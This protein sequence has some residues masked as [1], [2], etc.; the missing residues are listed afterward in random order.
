MLGFGYVLSGQLAIP[1]GLH[2]TWNFF[3][4]AVYGLPVSG[5]ETFGASFLSTEQVG[6]D[7]WTG[8]SFGP[9]GGCSA[10]PPCSW[11]SSLRAL[12]APAHGQ[13]SR[14]TLHRRGRRPVTSDP[15]RGTPYTHVHRAPRLIPGPSAD[16]ACLPQALFIRAL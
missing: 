15:G 14:F 2:L 12:G 5:F 4:N 11:A 16:P 6:P 8:G 9:E 1:I 7:L 10:P 3:Q 13:S